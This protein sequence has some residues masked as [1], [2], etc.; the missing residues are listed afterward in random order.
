MKILE[1]TVA[2]FYRFCCRSRDK[3]RLM[4]VSPLVTTVDCHNLTPVETTDTIGE[5]LD[6]LKQNIDDEQGTKPL[7]YKDIAIKMDW[8][9]LFVFMTFAVLS[10]IVFVKACAV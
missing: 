8:F 5:N 4:T 2:M 6:N 3:K 10:S 1:S 9:C 7:S